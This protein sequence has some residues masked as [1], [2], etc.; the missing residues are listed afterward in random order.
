MDFEMLDAILREMLHEDES[1]LRLLNGH[2]W[3]V[4]D[5]E[6]N[7]QLLKERIFDKHLEL[8]KEIS[9]DVL[10]EIDPQFELPA[11]ERWSAAIH[12]KN[13]RYSKNLREGI[14]E[15][16]VWL[17]INGGML[18]NCSPDKRRHVSLLAIRE[19]FSN[20]SWK[21]WGS[22][23]DLLPTLAEAAPGEFLNT[24]EHALHQ[25]PCPFDELFAQ[26]ESGIG[27]RN[28]MTGLLWAL[29]GLAWHEEY[30]VR[31][32][33]ILAELASHDPGGN[34]AN[35][36]SNSLTKI[37]LPWYP[38]TLASVE[39]RT[40]SIKAIKSDFPEIAW[41][42]LLS[43][44]PN[45]HQSSS[46][47]HKPRWR[48]RI[49]EDWKPSVTHEEYREQVTAYAAIAVDM[50]RAD[51]EKLKVLV[52]NLDN[53]PKPSFDN[54]L[55]Y[56]SSEAITGLTEIERLPIWSS[57]TDFVRK[58]RRFAD[59][60]WALDAETVSV[61]ETIANK[62][63]PVSP[64]GLYRRLFS[65]R[66]YDLYEEND[67]W[68]EQR[69]NLD[70][71]RQQAIQEILN[72]S[73]LQ[74]VLSFVETVKSP[75]QVGFALGYIADNEITS[76][77]LPEYLLIEDEH[78]KQFASGLVWGGF[79]NQG[80]QWIDGLD[81]ANWSLEQQCQLLL[82][83]PFEAET[84]RRATDWLGEV[85]NEYWQKVQVNPYQTGS[86][87]LPVID[88]LLEVARPQAAID[89]LYCRMH[90]KQPLDSGRTIRALLDAVSIKEPV[91]TVDS[92]HV[93]ELIKALQN[94]STTD[95]NELFKVEWAYLPLLDRHQDAKPKLIEKRLATQPDFFCEVIRLIYRSKHDEKKDENP[96]ESRQAI[97]TNAWRLLHEWKHPP[98]L[99]EEGS[100]S[101]SDFETWLASVKQQSSETGH[102]E[103]A[104]IK[105]G[106]VL[107][108][109][110]PDPQGLWIVQSVA[111]ALN[112]RDA[113]EMRNGFRTEV[114]NSRGVHWV[115]PSGK[116]ERE[117][118][119]QWRQK[120]DA[121]ENAGFARF[122]TVLHEVANSYDRD[123][124]RVVATHKFETLI[125]NADSG[126]DGGS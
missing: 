22:L 24:V 26:E 104:M 67:N 82:N 65:N 38:Q 83:L 114:F 115:D 48:K 64:E 81:R 19:I 85:E 108:Y 23:N 10:R 106:E 2:R 9:I 34:W 39:K 117:L 60:K 1:P 8:I 4:I 7:L 3:E 101:A 126:E 18:M 14:A 59:A 6:K 16:L 88:K 71:Q 63:V 31:V 57:L 96:D 53:L 47:T 122:A 112:A 54:V 97:A 41:K 29:E 73:G 68:E 69:K 42:V 119:E 66:D 15:S 79:Q 91:N 61:I 21:L 32:V 90:T 45:Q 80:W 55:E 49:S 111:S 70:K 40:V 56:L 52:R 13:L 76:R 36:P 93:T 72:A 20:S 75:H 62:L 33:V 77:L 98:G 25:T 103:V 5:K 78:A 99:Q 35:R 118:G 123:A 121:I 92:Y 110:P 28:Y 44:L 84:W 94:D 12:E 116:P 11:N 87:L 95:Q 109:C 120:A 30:L 43:L 100:F 107:L 89:C 86:G 37:L 51:I 58:H 27:G 46:G 124:E 102:F 50:A 125:Q 17:G 74:G 113:E 105:V